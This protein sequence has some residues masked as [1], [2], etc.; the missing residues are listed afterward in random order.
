MTPSHLPTTLLVLTRA[1]GGLIEIL[2]ELNNSV[3]LHR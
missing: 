3:C 2:A 1:A